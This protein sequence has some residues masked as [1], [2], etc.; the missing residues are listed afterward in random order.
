MVKRTQSEIM[1]LILSAISAIIISPFVYYRYIDGD[2]IV[3]FVDALIIL[4]LG[5]FFVFVYKTRKIATAK[6]ILAIFLVIA[7]VLAVSIRGQSHLYWLYPAIIAFYYT[8]P[9]RIAGVICL[10]AITLIALHISS[11]LSHI[12]FFT[13]VMSLLL[14]TIFS[15]TIFSNYRKTNEKL[16]LLATIDPLTLSGNRRALNIK[17]S[18][19]L[20]DQQRQASDV[21]LLLLDLDLFK[22]V[23]DQHGHAVG[24]Q[25]LVEVTQVLR[26]NTRA[27]D[28]L[29]RYGGEEFVIVPLK[30]DLA[31]ALI[32]AE[33]LRLLV[34]QHKYVNDLK[35][36]ISIGVA[37]YRVGET[38]E[39]WIARADAAL[40]K[41]K[42][43]GRNKVMSAMVQ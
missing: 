7:I 26:S 31:A 24:D 39:A 22:R 38:A 41:A 15:Y 36:T 1:L 30:V 10:I 37:Q 40:Y 32:V 43:A 2:V 11:T 4:A 3:A 12:N 29:F 13:I 16:A 19:I 35:I 42:D 20:A 34:A 9:E 23:N 18:E 5:I 17:L 8:L 21:S 25:V 6:M 27:L 14:T 33:K 28:A